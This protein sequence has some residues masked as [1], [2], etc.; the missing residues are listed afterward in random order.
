MKNL[1]KAESDIEI[2]TT[3]AIKNTPIANI[4][5]QTCGHHLHLRCWNSYLSSL[6]GA[7]RF[8]SD[9]YILIINYQTSIY[10]I[11]YSHICY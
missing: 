4:H 6:R 5:V 2:I 1:N 10:H 9:R 3:N 7:Q 11:K 8:N